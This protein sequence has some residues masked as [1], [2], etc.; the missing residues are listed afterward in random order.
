MP[1]PNLSLVHRGICGHRRLRIWGRDRAATSRRRVQRI[2]ADDREVPSPQTRKIVEAFPLD[3]AADLAGA[4]RGFPDRG[5]LRVVA[6]AEIPQHF[7]KFALILRRTSPRHAPLRVSNHPPSRSP[8]VA[9]LLSV[10]ATRCGD[11][12]FLWQRSMRPFFCSLGCKNVT[13]MSTTGSETTTNTTGIV[14]VTSWAA[15][16]AP[17]L[18]PLECPRWL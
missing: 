14:V 3:P 13:A 15:R 1:R 8:T 2:P 12:V 18:T 16:A 7:Q 11:Q 9:L 10:V 4:L 5:A 17:G 6:R